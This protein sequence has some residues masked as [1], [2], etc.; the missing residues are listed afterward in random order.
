MMIDGQQFLQMVPF[1]EGGDHTEVLAFDEEISG[2]D[3]SHIVF[4]DVSGE[5]D[6]L[7]FDLIDILI[8]N[9]IFEESC[10][11]CTRTKWSITN[12]KC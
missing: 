1:V 4:T 9:N 3:R 6:D 10:C 2:H 11:C 12:R 8:Y 5:V 7:V